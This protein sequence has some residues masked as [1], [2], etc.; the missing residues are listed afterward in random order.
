[1]CCDT[2]IVNKCNL[3]HS[4]RILFTVIRKKEK[5]KKRKKIANIVCFDDG[6]NVGSYG[7]SP[8]SFVSSPRAKTDNN[9]LNASVVV[10]ASTTTMK[11]TSGFTVPPETVL[12]ASVHDAEVESNSKHLDGDLAATIENTTTCSASEF[13]GEAGRYYDRHEATC[14]TASESSIGPSEQLDEVMKTFSSILDTYPLQYPEV[15]AQQSTEAPPGEGDAETVSAPVEQTVLSLVKTD[16]DDD[17]VAAKRTTD[18][19]SSMRTTAD[20]DAKVMQSRSVTS[21]LSA[22]TSVTSIASTA[23]ESR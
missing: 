11:T 21:I 17:F 4:P 10:T 13:T 9:K 3:R 14:E 15:V 8:A 23:S 18:G 6:D 19:I 12:V 20:T 5:K 1:M 16:V 7:L 22:G 2:E